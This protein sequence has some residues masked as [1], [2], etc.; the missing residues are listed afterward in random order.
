ML[1]ISWGKV[2]NRGESHY[3]GAPFFVL[4]LVR[5][6][7]RKTMKAIVNFNDKTLDI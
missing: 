3:C 7:L 2:I 5:E 6:R 4:I 1:D